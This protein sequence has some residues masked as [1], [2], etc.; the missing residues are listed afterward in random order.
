[1]GEKRPNLASKKTP[2]LGFNDPV[3]RKKGVNEGRDRLSQGEKRLLHSGRRSDPSKFR[4]VAMGG[5]R[6]V[7]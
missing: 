5:R 4:E 1:M 3:Y 6:R 7:V 2:F